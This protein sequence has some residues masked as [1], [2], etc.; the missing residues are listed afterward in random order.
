MLWFRLMTHGSHESNLVDR[1]V[2]GTFAHNYTG[3]FNMSYMKSPDPK[4]PNGFG[5]LPP[6]PPPPPPGNLGPPRKL[7]GPSPGPMG[8]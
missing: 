5:G 3:L 2:A 8:S 1:P 7:G 4:P 6:I